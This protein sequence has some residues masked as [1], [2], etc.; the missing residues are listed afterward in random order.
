MVQFLNY[1]FKTR[2]DA[3]SA[4]PIES[5]RI[6]NLLERCIFPKFGLIIGLSVET[7]EVGLSKEFFD[8]H[9]QTSISLKYYKIGFLVKEYS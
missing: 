8:H 5:M 2:S 4:F 7:C 3:F 6:S 9:F 1:F